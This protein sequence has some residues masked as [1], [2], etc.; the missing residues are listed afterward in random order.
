MIAWRSTRRAGRS[1]TSSPGRAQRPGQMYDPSG[2][3]V[4]PNGD[5]YTVEK[6]ADRLQRF[7][8]L[9][10]FV[11][12]IGTTGSGQRA[13]QQPGGGGGR[14]PGAGLRRGH[15]QLPRAGVRSVAHA[16]RPVRGLVVHRRRRC[17]RL[18]RV[19]TASR[20]LGRPCS[21]SA[22]R[23]VRTYDR[24]TGAPGATWASTG[25]TGIALDGDG[26]VWV[27]STSNVVREYT[28]GGAA[29]ATQATAQLSA[30]QG[31]AFKG[32][33]MFVADT[34][35][36]ADRAVLGR[37]TRDLVG[38][39]IGDRRGRRR[40]CRLRDRRDECATFDTS[41]TP[42]PTW[43]SPGSTGV[44]VDGSGNVWVSSSAG[45]I[46]EYDTSGNLLGT[47]GSTYLSR[48]EGTGRVRGEALRRGRRQDLSLLD[49]GRGPG[50]VVDVGGCLGRRGE[51]RHRLRGD[52]QRGSHVH[53]RRRDGP[54]LG[55]R[56]VIRDRPGRLG[57]RL[58]LVDGRADHPGIRYGGHAGID[59]GWTGPAQPPRWDRRRGEQAVRRRHRGGRGRPVLD[60]RLRPRMGRVPR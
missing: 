35:Q 46:N 16:R 52:D 37:D 17:E 58:G 42:G 11:S 34:G 25:G 6:G 59:G 41:G 3:A 23:P 33:T 40:G 10:N 39:G 60:R 20:C 29:L 12:S 32:T 21:R 43:S 53:D 49:G 13:V 4:A 24:V 44:A 27:T 28:P 45:V 26:N 7:D 1:S 48:P 55:L 14:R 2:V 47:V 8:S 51:R 36:R 22:A 31:L 38:G 15:R 5:V 19:A 57:E 18:L 30:P 9:G 54:D 56:L 50:N